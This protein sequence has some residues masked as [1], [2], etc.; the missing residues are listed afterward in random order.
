V[1]QHSE[2]CDPDNRI[3]TCLSKRD[4]QSLKYVDKSP[5]ATSD[6]EPLIPAFDVGNR[7]MV[8][9][10]VVAYGDVH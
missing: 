8:S 5:L 2:T 9:D 7:V 1:N 4:Q 3:Q 6:G 10:L